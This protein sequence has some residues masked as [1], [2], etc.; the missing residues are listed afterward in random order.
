[1]KKAPLLAAVL[2]GV[3]AV[4]LVAA[5]PEL[6]PSAPDAAADVGTLLAPE[7][8]VLQSIAVIGNWVYVLAQD[9]ST[10]GM[11][12][13]QYRDPWGEEARPHVVQRVQGAPIEELTR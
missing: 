13:I 5:S 11:Y 12:L 9:T 2:V 6:P 4:V 7:G 1:M 10:S 8:A 3:A